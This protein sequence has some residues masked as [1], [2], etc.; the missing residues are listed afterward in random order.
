MSTTNQQARGLHQLYTI[1]F[2]QCIY[3]LYII[4]E[5]KNRK[6]KSIT[7][8]KKP[9]ITTKNTTKKAQTISVVV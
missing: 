1:F 2:H 4:L 6:L 7:K 9:M 8:T 3:N 5:K